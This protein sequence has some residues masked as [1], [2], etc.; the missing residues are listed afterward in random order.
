MYLCVH[1]REWARKQNA[2]QTNLSTLLA[3]SI[4]DKNVLANE[5]SCNCTRKGVHWLK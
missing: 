5:Y 2:M 4:Q 1:G 3:H